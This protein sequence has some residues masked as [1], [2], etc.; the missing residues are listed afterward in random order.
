MDNIGGAEEMY[1]HTAE[2]IN[3]DE[4]DQMMKFLHKLHLK[5]KMTHHTNDLIFICMT[6]NI[7][8]KS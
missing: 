5:P 1:H 3:M 7:S 2:I 8:V 6:S 4:M